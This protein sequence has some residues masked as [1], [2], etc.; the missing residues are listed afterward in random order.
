MAII[1]ASEQFIGFS[2]TLNIPERRSALINSESQPY[3]M[4][5]FIDTISPGGQ[6][7]QGPVG[8]A[9]ATGPQ[10]PTGA[11][12]PI[13]ATGAQGLVGPIGPAGLNWQGGW[14]ALGTYVVDDAVGYGGA[15]YFCI[16]NVGPSITTPDIDPLNWALLANIGATGATGPTGPQGPQ[17]VIGVT[18][19]TGPQGIQGIQGIAG[20]GLAGTQYV[21]VEANGSPI[22][23]STELQNAYITAQGMSPSVTNR[24]TII[25]APGNYNFTVSNFL[26]NTDYIDFVSL[27]GNASVVFI[28]ATV[29]VSALETFIKGVD[30][31]LQPFLIVSPLFS[32]KIENCVGGAQSFAGGGSTSN[33]EFIDC[34]GGDDSF[35]GGGGIANGMYINC[36]GGDGAFGGNGGVASGTF[37]NCTG[38]LKCFAEGAAG[39]ASGRFTSCTGGDDSF[40]GAGGSTSGIFNSCI[41]GDNSFG[42]SG[43]ADGVFNNCR[44]GVMSFGGGGGALTGLLYYCRITA[45]FFATVSG[46]GRTVLC[47]DGNNNQ[48]NQ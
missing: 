7:P 13:G 23:N 16:A 36:T 46:S 25:A 15:S 28:G 3:T 21:Y 43:V 42:T 11:Q 32:G 35:G 12:G 2:Q 22:A 33:G 24:I 1:S 39:L 5:D 14:S 47:I 18:G 48:N 26:M 37:I 45:G 8:P 20:V 41:G 38:G 9:G 34:T 31:G 6:G 40:G 29:E 30:V 19:A 44:G 4:Q 17:G 10:G 27:D